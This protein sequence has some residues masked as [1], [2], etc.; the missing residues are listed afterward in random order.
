MIYNT[1]IAPS[2]TGDFHIG[3]ARTALL[4]YLAAK[5]SGGQFLLRI[6]DTDVERSR[7]EFTKVIFEMINWLGLMP[8]RVVHQSHRLDRYKE[9][10][11]VLL[12]IGRAKILNGAIV[13]NVDT[14]PDFFIDEIKGQIVISEN[15]K[16]HIFG[17]I[18]RSKEEPEGLVL[19]RQD[20]QPTYHFACVV[21]D[22]DFNINYVIRGKDHITN[23]SR[24]VAIYQALGKPLPKYAHL[25]LIF[26]NGKKLSKRDGACSMLHYKLEGYDPDGLL[27]FLVRM[28]WGPTKEYDH[29]SALLTRQQMLE[30]FFVGGKMSSNDCSL[31]LNILKSYDRKHKFLK[32]QD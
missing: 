8:D 18:S 32:K 2:P 24:Q 9:M 3:T 4:N 25:G 12:D 28:G 14:L 5:A 19:M 17:K 10:A 27:N 21:D 11:Q 6:D 23:T 22:I 30:Y 26:Q 7:D 31:D 13:L 1:R 20:Q 16:A 29:R 15:D